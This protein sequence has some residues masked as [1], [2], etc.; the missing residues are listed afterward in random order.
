MNVLVE[1]PWDRVH[2]YLDSVTGVGNAVFHYADTA[3]TNPLVVALA[4]FSLGAF[5]LVRKPVP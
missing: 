1:D 5:L 2:Y 4:A 3:V